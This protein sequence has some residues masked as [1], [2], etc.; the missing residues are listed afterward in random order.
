MG[1]LSWDIFCRVIDNLGDIGVCWR[2]SR[3]LARQGDLVRLWVDDASALGFMAPQGAPGVTVRHWADPAPDD[4]P[5]DIVVEA[6][7]CDPPP[8]FVERMARMRP[9]PVWINLE[10]LSAEPASMRNHG[11]CSPQRN[12]PNKWFFYPGFQDGTGGLMREHDLDMRRSRFDRADWLAA[13]GAVPQAGERVVSLFCY[14][15][16]ELA[17]WWE[18]LAARPTLLLLTPGWATEQARAMAPRTGLRTAALPW[19]D[20][21]GYDELLWASDLNFVRGE[22]SLVRALWAGKPL[23]WQIYPQNDGAHAVKLDAFLQIYLA[24]AEPELARTVRTLAQG[25]AGVGSAAQAPPRDAPLPAEP[26]PAQ[27]LGQA[28]ALAERL[29]AGPEL[30]LSLRAYC[31]GKQAGGGVDGVAAISG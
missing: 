13:H 28:H 20:Q 5:A 19:L 23:L 30:S 12:G 27:W 31:L 11:L 1:R 24:G 26:D 9:A 10:Y 7:G 16:P 29:S 17:R 21:D 2:L 3:Q 18:W 25:W 22:D 4:Q 14:E 8:R 6:F 15:Q